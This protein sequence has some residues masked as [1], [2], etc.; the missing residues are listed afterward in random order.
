MK[1]ANFFKAFLIML[2]KFARVAPPLFILLC[3]AFFIHGAARA[4]LVPATQLFLERAVDF[5]ARRA[6]LPDAAAGLAL[7]GLAHVCRQLFHGVHHILMIMYWRRAEGALSLEYHNK[8]GRIA[9]ERFEDTQA[10]DDMDKALRGKDEAVWFTGSLVTVICFY[11][12]YFAFMAAYLT[13]VKPALIILLALVFTPTLLAHVFRTKVFSKAEDEAAPFRREFEYYEQCLA[14]REYFK[15]T[16]I[17]GAFSYFRKL[18]ADALARLNKLDFRASK[19]AAGAGLCVKLLSL[20]GYIGILLLLFD[21]LIKGEIG[22]GAFAAIFTSLEMVFSLMR[23]LIVDMFGESA[24]NLSR[25]QNYFSFLQMPERGGAEAELPEGFG[26]ELRGVSYTY[27]NATRKAVDNVTACIRHGETVAVVGEN[28]SGKTTLIRLLAGLYMPDA[29]EILYGG[30][31]TKTASAPSLYKEISAVF[32]NYQRYQMTL[33]EN[34]GIGDV[35]KAASDS[36]LDTPC[37]QSG[38]DINDGNYIGGYDTMLSRE[39]DGADL[40]G[41]QWQRVAIAR[42][43]FR[44]RRLIFLDEPTAAIDPIEETKIY[45]RFAEISRGKT[46]VIV[47]HRLGSVRLADRIFVMKRGKLAEQGAHAELMA[48]NGEYARLYRSQEQWYRGG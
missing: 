15:E 11:I 37:A 45:N 34:I 6:A 42:G 5:A 29:G 22:A 41:G 20:S 9:P 28:G 36:A 4:A 14:G 44:A 47:T 8:A 16:R 1:K 26:V 21:L 3:A 17:L 30:I 33:R 40:S 19:R 43:F 31:D 12:P 7:L 39:F 27:R 13:G 2:P 46:A 23:E 32:Q 24:K 25:M 38:I 10:L 18:Y 48:A 35:K